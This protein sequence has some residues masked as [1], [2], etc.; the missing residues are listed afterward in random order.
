MTGNASLRTR[1]AR[2][3]R[4]ALVFLDP[5]LAGSRLEE[6][7]LLVALSP[8]HR[9]DSRQ[10]RTDLASAGQYAAVVISAHGVPPETGLAGGEKAGPAGLAQALAL[11]SGERLTSAEL[12]TCHLPDAF[13]TPSCWS[14]RLTVRTAIEP[15]GLPTAA[16]VAGAR[17]VLAGTV[18]IGSFP[19]GRLMSAFYERLGAGSAPSAALQH[20]QVNFLRRRPH[21]MP[22]VWAGLTI[23]GDGFTSLIRRDS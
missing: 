12:L 21:T 8:L 17:W 11:A 13:I 20:A 10:L 22:G 15:L 23:V 3:G 2:P 16:L 6:A 7:A 1:P 19:T 14:G 5:E 9:V 18:A 4:G